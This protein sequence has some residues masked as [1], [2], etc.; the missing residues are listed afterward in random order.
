MSALLHETDGC[1]GLPASCSRGFLRGVG[2]YCRQ[3]IA[4]AELAILHNSFAMVQLLFLLL[5][6][7]SIP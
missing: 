4:E 7:P 3:E 1:V 5:V 6:E 2:P